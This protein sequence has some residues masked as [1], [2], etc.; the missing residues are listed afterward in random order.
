MVLEKY[1]RK[2]DRKEL[3]VALGITGIL[4]CILFTFPRVIKSVYVILI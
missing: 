1:E 4:I 2:A 3:T